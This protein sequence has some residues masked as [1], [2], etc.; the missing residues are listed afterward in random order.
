MGESAMAEGPITVALEDHYTRTW[1]MLREAIQSFPEDT[2]LQCDN[3]RML[4][5]RI[6]YHLLKGAERYAF[7]G[8]AEQYAASERT[9]DLDWEEAPPEQ[10]PTKA[11]LLEHF[12]TME[13]QTLAWLHAYGDEGLANDKPVFPW[14]GRNALAQALY[15]LR[16]LQHHMAELN[17]ELIR[18]GLPRGD[19]K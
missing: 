5:A 14:T 16:H 19:W 7:Q 15:H 4:P 11:Q 1:T 8:T 2:W 3:P 12:R 9:F 6:G 10:F 17:S 13:E 18:R